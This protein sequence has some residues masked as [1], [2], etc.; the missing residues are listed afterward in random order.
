MS[1]WKQLRALFLR[2]QLDRE[3]DEEIRS[4]I[5]LA[6][7]DYIQRGLPQDEAL[8][9]AHYDPTEQSESLV[10]EKEKGE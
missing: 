8:R 6:T 2:D 7:E 9:P 10:E 4:N 3:L 5:R 1:A